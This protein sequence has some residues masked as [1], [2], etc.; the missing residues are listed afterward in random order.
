MVAADTALTD[1]DTD[2]QTYRPVRLAADTSTTSTTSTTGRPVVERSATAVADDRSGPRVRGRRGVLADLRACLFGERVQ[3][4]TEDTHRAPLMSYVLTATQSIAVV[5]ILGHA[6]IPL[7]LSGNLGISALMAGAL[8]LLI[9]TVVVADYAAIRTMRR[10]PVLARNRTTFGLWEH[11]AYLAFVLFTELSTY[12]LVLSVLDR[13]PR[14]LLASAP[15]VPVD[16]PIYW[17][18]IVLRAAL[19]TWTAVQLYVVS[20]PLPIQWSTLDTMSLGLLGGHAK[21]ELERLE[22][23]QTDIA[24]LFQAFGAVSKRPPRRRTW[25][26]GLLVR[27]DRDTEAAEIA[28]QQEVIQALEGLSRERSLDLLAERTELERARAAA[29][30][31]EQ[32]AHEAI[33]HANA[34]AMQ[35]ARAQL[36][37]AFLHLLA[38]GKAPEWL[39]EL[40]PNAADILPALVSKGRRMAH[41]GA[42][43]AGVLSN[44]VSSPITGGSLD[45]LRAILATM[46]IQE[47][48]KPEGIRRGIWVKSS[49]I[50][51]ISGGAL[52]GEEATNLARRLGNGV[53]DG[54]TYVL[55]LEALIGELADR[56][57]LHNAF[58]TWLEARRKRRESAGDVSADGSDSDAI[59]A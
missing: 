11:C 53:R 44:M 39:V 3:Q 19:L 8:A 17:A 30:Q 20:A 21:A 6:E 9:A 14:G 42:I 38:T 32:D 54:R 13:N 34:E 50:D 5:L 48:R 27:R 43:P 40:A 59:P 36:A 12:A 15:L 24:S 46:G 28:H 7:L 29:T 1:T 37:E 31:A 57:K 2:A 56:N 55:P 10:I 51:A 52:Q 45:D 25:W 18:Q 22:L 49:D 47:A 33:R 23:K 58:V 16:G 41:T 35:A 4:L 26:N